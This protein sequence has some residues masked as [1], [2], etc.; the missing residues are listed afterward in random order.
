M[1]INEIL[2]NANPMVHTEIACTQDS[3]NISIP[4]TQP[5]ID[6]CYCDFECEY[7]ELKLV[8][9]GNEDFKNDKSRFIEE[10]VDSIGG[11]ITFILFKDGIQKAVIVDD[12]YGTFT[13]LGD[14]PSGELTDQSL[15]S[16]FICEWVKVEE[17]FGIGKYTIKTE[18]INFTRLITKETWIYDVKLYSVKAANYSFVFKSLQNGYIQGG[19]DYTGLNWEYE[20]RIQG[21][22]KEVVPESVT[23]EFQT[24][25]DVENQIQAQTIRAYILYFEMIPGALYEILIDDNIM[26]NNLI[27]RDYNIWNPGLSY[28]EKTLALKGVDDRETFPQS[29]LINLSLEMGDRKKDK[30]KRNYK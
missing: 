10:V 26:G 14:F 17:D 11:T 3:I 18:I 5:T 24:S 25:D 23:T 9:P 30:I 12:T 20:Y 16:G 27:V 2:G 15:K 8:S 7:E 1:A 19:L 22:L 28:V 6:F 13:P 4:E 21:L 29:Q